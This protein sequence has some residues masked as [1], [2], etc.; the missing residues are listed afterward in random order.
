MKA[1]HRSHQPPHKPLTATWK[2]K[3]KETP[4]YNSKGNRIFGHTLRNVQKPACGKLKNTP[5]G[6]ESGLKQKDTL[7]DEGIQTS[8]RCQSSLDIF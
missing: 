1:K 8:S 2:T 5:K 3:E 4:I 7:F 6:N